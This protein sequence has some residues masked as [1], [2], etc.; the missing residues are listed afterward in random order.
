M[1]TPDMS[2]YV[3]DPPAEI[4]KPDLS[5]LITEDDTPVDNIFSAKQQRLLVEPLYSSW[6]PLDDQGQPYPF[7]ADANVGIYRSTRIP[8]VVPDM[9]LSLDVQVAE[10]W[11]A[12]A[13]R[14]YLL[15]E[16]GKPPEVVV[17]IVSNLKGRELDKKLFEYARLG[18]L[19][20]VI[21]DP[22]NLLQP[23]PLAVYA[24]SF[25]E[26]VLQ[27]DARLEKIGLSL[28]LWNGEF[29]SKATEWLRWAD[30]DGDLIPTGA[31]R[32]G[33]E[34]VRADQERVRAGQE[35][36][37]AD[38]ERVRADQ[39]RVRAEQEHARAERLAAQLR[40]LGIEPEA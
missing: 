18:V 3:L 33:Q 7:L 38:Q 12:K 27:P 28:V 5:H 30:V 4:E 10:D 35:R 22:Q 11:F 23:V 24:L 13:N 26:Y 15:W 20:Y 39:E 19:Y 21:Y 2:E 25:G 36:V 34:R 16:F 17:E 29:E 40:A 14:S 31:E 37:R 6:N 9:F 32:A 1:E 8:P